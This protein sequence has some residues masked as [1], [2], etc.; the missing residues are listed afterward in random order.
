VNGH[1][2]TQDPDKEESLDKG[3]EDAEETKSDTEEDLVLDTSPEPK[4]IPQ[5]SERLVEE[6]KKP[7]EERK[8]TAEKKG[9][10]AQDKKYPHSERF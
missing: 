6:K 5:K 1:E 10:S 2:Y 7:V 9:K 4:T 8:K 3:E